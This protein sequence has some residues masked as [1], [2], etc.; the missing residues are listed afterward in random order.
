M[1]N[2]R[3]TPYLRT[4]DGREA[5]VP[6]TARSGTK[7]VDDMAPEFG[8]EVE[9]IAKDLIDRLTAI[10][11][12]LEASFALLDRSHPPQPAEVRSVIEKA[13]AQTIS[14]GDIV[15]GLRRL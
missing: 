6:S 14:A 3:A 10:A 7:R 8:Q 1:P 13:H 15:K 4:A 11:N 12:Y 2:E 9:K 5:G